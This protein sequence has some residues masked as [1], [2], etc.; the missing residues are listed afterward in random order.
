[1]ATGACG[2]DCRACSL[3]IRGFCMGCG[4]GTGRIAN[5]KLDAQHRIFGQCCP[6]LEC[7]R[8][9]RVAV[10]LRDCRR[11]PCRIFE[12]GP[13]PFSEAFLRIQKRLR[14]TIRDPS[15]DLKEMTAWESEELDPYYWDR[16]IRSDPEK[17]CRRAM[18][19]F[20][21]DEEAY[22]LNFLGRPYSIYPFLRTL[23][24]TGRSGTDSPYRKDRIPF[25]EGVVLLSYLLKAKEVPLSERWV[26]EK[27]LPGG[28]A[29][30]RGP[31]QLTSE[32][33]L[34]RYGRDPAGLLEAGRCLG[35]RSV[36]AGDAA[37]RINALPRVPLNYILW[38]EDDE[39]PPRLTVA[40]DASAPEHLPLDVIWALVHVV[41]NRLARW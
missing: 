25:A 20:R 30:F 7:A 41:T 22:T 33:V 6:I 23:T 38:K 18:V 37:I 14:S 19:S 24:R 9:H 10:C 27:D 32:P 3:K 31:H 36:R 16:L 34:K 13:A 5:K 8:D 11:F 21:K 15:P 1:M 39:F 26:T 35:G 17:V 12:Q 28:E 2:I 4:A 40:F 29:F